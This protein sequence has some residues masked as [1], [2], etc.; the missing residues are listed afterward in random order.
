MKRIFI[1]LLAITA[2]LCSCTSTDKAD[3]GSGDDIISS[4]IESGVDENEVSPDGT[5]DNIDEV[6]DVDKTEDT[7]KTEDVDKTEETNK[8]EDIDKNE[9]E[10]KVEDEAQICH[11]FPN[12]RWIIRPAYGFDTLETFGKTGY[13]IYTLDGKYGIVDMSA[14]GIGTGDYSRLFYCPSHG[15]SCPDIRDA[16]IEMREDLYLAPD[17][18][19]EYNPETRVVYVF[20]PT[21]DRVYATGYSDGIFRIMD[22]TET[23]FFTTNERYTVVLYDCDADLLMY[24]GIG[25]P[26]IETVFAMENKE[27]HYGVIDTDMDYVIACIYDE[28][29]DGNDCYIVKKDGK[30]GYRALGGREYYPCVFES[31]QTAYKGAAWVKYGGLWGTVRF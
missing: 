12:D 31:A 27:M 30:Y 14:N 4:V 19:Y 23:E 1:L 24:E 25:M 3:D 13:S 10:Q 2:V 9:D 28:I 16:S 21:R 5:K 6:G 15:L 8:N 18:G 20:D 11:E 26:D 17:C 29:L 7:D 22:I